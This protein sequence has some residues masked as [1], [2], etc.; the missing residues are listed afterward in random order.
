MGFRNGQVPGMSMVSEISVHS[1]SP[2]L[3]P[4]HFITQLRFP[5]TWVVPDPGQLRQAGALRDLQG[6][7]GP[8]VA[9]GV[10]IVGLSQRDLQFL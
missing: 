1:Q 9:R 10:D 6:V 3:S 4:V 7:R 5:D 8:G 2:S